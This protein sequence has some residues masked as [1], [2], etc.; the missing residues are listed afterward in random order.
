[1][2]EHTKRR[3]ESVCHT[4]PESVCKSLAEETRSTLQQEAQGHKCRLNER[5]RILQALTR[6]V[7]KK[8]Y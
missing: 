7:S 4:Q 2:Q 1:M 3:V 8:R 5:K 6:E